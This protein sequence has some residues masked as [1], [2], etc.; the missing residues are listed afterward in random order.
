MEFIILVSIGYSLENNLFKEWGIQNP[1]VSF[2]GQNLITLSKL[3]PIDPETPSGRL[4][5]YP[6]QKTYNIGLNITF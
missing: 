3:G 1:V 2:S 6:Q 4:S 5:Y